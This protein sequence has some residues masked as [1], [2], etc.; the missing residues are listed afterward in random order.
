MTDGAIDRSADRPTDRP[1][2]RST[3]GPTDRRTDRPI[4]RP[5]DRPIDR[6]TDRP[7]NRPTDRPIDTTQGINS[8]TEVFYCPA[9]VYRS[10]RENKYFSFLSWTLSAVVFHGRC[11]ELG[12]SCAA[13]MLRNKCATWPAQTQQ[14]TE[15]TPE[16]RIYVWF[17]MF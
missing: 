10:A 16:E 17:M 6:S 1:T 14:R 12:D 7:T 3:D 8:K 2:D 15:S 9:M 4:D 13:L 11:L 5:A